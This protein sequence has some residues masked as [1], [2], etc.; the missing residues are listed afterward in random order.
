MAKK[1]FTLLAEATIKAATKAKICN[2]IFPKQDLNIV[3]H[4]LLCHQLCYKSCTLGYRCSFRKASLIINFQKSLNHPHST[5][6]LSLFNA[7]GSVHQTS[8]SKL[9]QIFKSKSNEENTEASK[10]NTVYVVDLMELMQ[11]VMAIPETFADLAFKLI[12]ILAN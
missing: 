4:E 6:T 10:G 3:A 12:S 9:A 1:I 8:K 2:F 5:I 7:D 11:M